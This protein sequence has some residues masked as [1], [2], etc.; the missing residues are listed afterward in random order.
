MS[1]HNNDYSI[2]RK[3]RVGVHVQ[4]KKKKKRQ[5]G[6][7]GWLLTR[8]LQLELEQ[9]T[10]F[11]VMETNKNKQKNRKKT[12]EKIKTADH[13]YQSHDPLLSLDK[14]E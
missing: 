2:Q 1:V 8:Q 10:L 13:N 11:S 7:L 4:K 3:E 6:N 14:P 12:A 9:C 5:E